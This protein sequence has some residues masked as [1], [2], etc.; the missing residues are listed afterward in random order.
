[1]KQQEQEIKE[2]KKKNIKQ[3][4]IIKKKQKSHSLILNESKILSRIRNKFR[5][6]NIWNNND[7]SGPETGCIGS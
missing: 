2:K 5:G 1:M 7:P 3:K 6:R 4:T